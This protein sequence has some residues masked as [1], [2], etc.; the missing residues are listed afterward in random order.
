MAKT[1]FIT[2]QPAEK[3][4]FGETK[5]VATL[6]LDGNMSLK[7]ICDVVANNTTG[8]P[9]EVLGLIRAYLHQIKF[10]VLNGDPVNIA[11]LGTFYPR[12]TTKMVAS[13]D[14]VTV[15][16]CVKNITI[17]FRPDKAV[18]DL[19]KDSGLKEFKKAKNAANPQ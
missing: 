16:N 13:I 2:Y 8:Q 10:H 6:H 9:N 1:K 14:D 18:R 12:V 15:E 11:G 7:S 5:W 19:V 17:G 4:V 3:K